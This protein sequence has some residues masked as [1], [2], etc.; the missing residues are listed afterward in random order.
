M[1][2]VPL[3]NET[4]GY[5]VKNMIN[6]KQKI[7]LEKLDLPKH[8]EFKVFEQIVDDLESHV[9]SSMWNSRFYKLLME[10]I[11]ASKAVIRSRDPI[12]AAKLSGEIGTQCII[13][14][15]WHTA[16][17]AEAF[18]V[19]YQ[20]GAYL[21][22]FPFR[23][24]DTEQPAMEKFFQAERLCKL[25]N[26]ENHKAIVRLDSIAHWLY[27]NC[28]DEI[29]SDIEKLIG[30]MPN[31]DR[32]EE[33]AGH[34]PGV[35]LGD[36]YRYGQSTSYYKWAY[37]PYSVTEA[38]LPMA[39]RAIVNDPRWIGALDEWYRRR[40][41]NFFAPIDMTDFW[42][43]IFTVVPGSR[44]TTVPK[45]ALTDRTIAIEP[46]MNVY[47][48][49]GVDGLLKSALK[50]K[51]SIDLTTQ[52]VNQSFAREG[53]ISGIYSTL[54]LSMASDLISLKVC[55]M[56]LPE[57]WLD[58]MLDL[59]SPKGDVGGMA[60]PFEK[61]SSMGNGFT[62]ALETLLFAAICRHVYRRMGLT[63]PIA[64]YGDDIIIA[65]AASQ[66]VVD[67]LG[68]FGFKINT[69]KSFTRGPFRESCGS[70]WF[71]RYN[72]RP[73]FQTR[74]FRTVLD[75]FYAHNRLVELETE[76]D[77]TWGVEFVR[78]KKFLRKYIPKKYALIKGPP[79]EMLDS[80]LFV[81]SSRTYRKAGWHF[82]LAARPIKYNRKT[83][84]F[85]RKLMALQKP[86][87]VMDDKCVN[88]QERLNV[89]V[90]GMSN[91]AVRDAWFKDRTMGAR[92]TSGNVFDVTRRDAVQIYCTK[93]RVW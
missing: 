87:S 21:K 39:K 38:A 82:V 3:I 67:L 9:S 60:H 72:V 53:A 84:F 47:L 69:D 61:I 26:E 76:L 71:F 79:G 22:K 6:R 66:H 59:R 29:R 50:R 78:T 30:V 83:Q 55:E 37:L 16:Q 80:H 56:L 45:T 88:L 43:R 40:C 11:K 32:V 54:D 93:R 14:K 24:I 63:E 34:G 19:L 73:M 91:S 75:V 42:S 35:S 7:E 52:E 1:R 28:I 13:D 51:W 86:L 2:N 33:C 70:D 92:A 77:W 81:N 48:Q 64:V 17:D 62:F 8:F 49:L 27:G 85:F 46:L 31:C 57:A 44:I 15:P 68:L 89:L 23:G 58:L 20:L 12:R 90:F 65:T 74:P 18:Y 4:G 10:A 5:H 25:F 36:M 41:G